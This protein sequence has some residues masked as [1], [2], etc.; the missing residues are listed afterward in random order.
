MTFA[1]FGAVDL[2]PVYKQLKILE[3]PKICLLET[4]KFEFEHQKEPLPTQICNHFVPQ[5]ISYSHGL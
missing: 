1:P 3:V 5:E 4:G 2:E